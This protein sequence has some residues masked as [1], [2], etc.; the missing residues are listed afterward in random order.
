MFILFCFALLFPE[1]T[2]FFLLYLLLLCLLVVCLLWDLTAETVAGRRSDGLRLFYDFFSAG[3]YCLRFFCSVQMEDHHHGPV[4]VVVQTYGSLTCAAEAI[5]ALLVSTLLRTRALTAQVTLTCAHPCSFTD[6]FSLLS[7][8]PFFSPYFVWFWFSF[9]LPFVLSYA[10][11]L[12]Y[13]CWSNI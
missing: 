9:F 7:L 11:P 1:N 13:A 2:F 5:V 12:T 6:S 10:F 8:S 3:F 4:T